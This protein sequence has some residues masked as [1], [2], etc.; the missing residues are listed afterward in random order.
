MAGKVKNLLNRDGRYFSRIVV[1]RELRPFLDNKTELREALGPDRRAALARHATALAGLQAQIAVAERKAKIARGERITPGRYPLP[2]DQ[3]ALRNYNERLSFDDLLRNSGPRWT[4]V[5]ID[6][7]HVALLRDGIAG[8]LNDAAL[9][10]L[11]GE[12]IDRYRSL[13]NT[14]V[15]NGSDEWRTLARALCMSELEA[16]ARVAERDEGDFAGKPENPMLAKAVEVDEIAAD[17]SEAEFNNLTF[18]AVIQEKERLTG[19]GLGGNEKSASTLEKYRQT[20]HDFEHHRRSKKVASV[21]LEE[22][23]AWR[24]AM[25]EAGKLSRKTIRDK[26]AAIRAILTWGQE[27]CRGKLFPAIPKGTPFDY[28]ELPVAEVKDSADRTYTLEQARK[29]LEAA[30]AEVARPNFRWIPWLLAHSGMRVGE[31]LQLERA[32]VVELEGNWFMHIRVGDGR[33]TKTRKG[34]KVP[35]HQALVAEGFIEWIKER[36]AGK[37]FPGTFQDQRL[38]EWIKEGPLKDVDNAPPPNHGFRHLFEDALFGG[39]S[40]KAALYITGRSSGSSAD[41]YG[42]SDV[43]LLEL[44]NQMRNVRHFL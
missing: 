13:G 43:K 20:V 21:T 15:V 24:N 38:R 16:L 4:S 41:D 2:V 30:R 11:V 42:G 22:G 29:V 19:M 28:L 39:V 33:T 17:V 12:R 44:A 18:E 1:P 26:L 36:P 6:D 23:E 35:I 9:E 27:Q 7:L 37:L 34:R 25:L 10:R 8:K 32:D 40:N 31:A 5:G 3:I 14:T